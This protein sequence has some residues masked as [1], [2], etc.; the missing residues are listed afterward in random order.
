MLPADDAENR[1]EWF[2]TGSEPTAKSDWYQRI[3]IC[4]IDGRVSNSG[5]KDADETEVKTFVKVRAE[6]PEWQYG[7]DAW[8]KE[9]YTKEEKYFPP[10]MTSALEFDGDEVSNKD[11]VE[12][13]IMD[14][15]DG[16]KVYLDFRLN[17]EVS[18]YK[19]VEVVR[20]YMDDSKVGE[21][22][23]LPYGY[24]LNLSAKDIGEHEFEVSVT[25]EDGNKGSKKIR[26]NVVGYIQ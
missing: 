20:F 19:D 24:N 16:D 23:S 18:S 10:Q 17:A 13:G 12:V 6:L 2:I 21:D 22:K 11:N 1:T 26:L 3:E 8:V 7:V 5:C 15:K 9:N 14:L 25:D 4:K